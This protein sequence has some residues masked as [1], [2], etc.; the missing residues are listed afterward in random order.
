MNLLAKATACP[1][2]QEITSNERKTPITDHEIV[3]KFFTIAPKSDDS[4]IEH[5]ARDDHDQLAIFK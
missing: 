3:K 5:T 2:L 1:H 4:Y